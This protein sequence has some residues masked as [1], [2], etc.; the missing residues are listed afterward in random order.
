MCGDTS[1]FLWWNFIFE[2]HAMF[3]WRGQ[4]KNGCA[5]FQHCYTTSKHHLLVFSCI[6]LHYS[7]AAHQSR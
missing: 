2:A 7:A 5:C 6:Q 3:D 1:G 4:G